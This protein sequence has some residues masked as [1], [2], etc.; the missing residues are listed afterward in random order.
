MTIQYKHVDLAKDWIAALRSGEYDQGTGALCRPT[1]TGA[2]YCCLGVLHEVERGPSAWL[3]KNMDGDLVSVH[4]CAGLYYGPAS[5]ACDINGKDTYGQS[6]L[7]TLNDGGSTFEQ[8][9]NLIES[10]LPADERGTIK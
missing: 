10:H 3:D 6:G 7:T 4:G 2:N 9:A 5:F 1:K 8:I